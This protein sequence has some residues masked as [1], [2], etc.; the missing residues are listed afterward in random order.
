MTPRRRLLALS[1]AVLAVALG[2]L[3]LRTTDG[4]PSPPTP[5]PAGGPG[6]S[7]PE[8]APVPTRLPVTLAPAEA[9]AEP[10]SLP[11]SFEGRVVSRTTGA[12]VPGADLTFSR[13]GVAASARAGPS[14]AFRFLPPE[15]GRWL[16][17]AVTAPG[18]LPFAPE[19][20]HS[21]VQLDARKGRHVRGVEIHLAPAEEILGRVVDGEGAP[22]SGAEVRLLG[23]SGEAALVSIPDRFVSDGSGEFRFAA[24]QGSLVVARK[25]GLA[26]GRAEVDLLAIANGRLTVEIGPAHSPFGAPGRISGRVV[27]DP[28]GAPVPG[29]LVVAQAGRGALAGFPAGQTISLSDGTFALEGLEPGRYWLAARAE[30]RAPATAGRVAPG[31]SDVVLSLGAGGRL[32]GCVRDASSGAPVAP[33]TVLVY[34]RG[35]TLFR[36]LQRSASVVDASGCFALDDLRPGPA[37]VVVSAPTHAPSAEVP[38]EIAGD[39]E[40]VTDVALQ[41]GGRLTGIVRT[42][43]SGRPIPGA[44]LAV[45]GALSDAASTFP[46]LAEATT[47]PDGTFALSGLPRRFSV[48]AAAAG[49]HARI[50]GGVEVPPGGAAGP[51]EILLRPAAEGEEPRV[52]LAGI[53]IG[54]APHRDALWITA[55]QAG[56]GAAEVGLARGDLVL[57]VDGRPV[58]E[59]GMSGSV[60]AIRGPEGTSVLLEVRRGESTFEVRVPRRL[61]RG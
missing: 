16:L 10:D 22:V 7:G 49:H 57:K 13:G 46:V 39:R 51:I 52:E 37:A 3:L 23:A 50:A 60:D 61:V 44:R 5:S 58:G 55:V 48:L 18:Y 32:R 11:P 25:A 2:A 38:V 33:F 45:E 56:G 9:G 40:A 53:G 26:P 54:V 17:A 4:A 30:G 19:W 1:I 15:E 34:D 14:G 36:S 21:P 6:P 59:M 24:P 28:G 43:G 27:E 31:T 42:L 8:A 12:G 29:A 35:R 41:A 47:G 20:G